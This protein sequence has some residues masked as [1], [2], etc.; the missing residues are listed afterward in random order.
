VK[1]KPN[2]VAGT[3]LREHARVGDALDISSPR[4]SF[5]LQPGEQP[6]LLLSAGIGAKPVLAMLHALVADRSTRQ[7]LWVHAARD[8]R[9]HPF[10]DEVRALMRELARGRSY[11]CYSRPG[12]SD[13]M[14]EDFDA[15][16][17]L[18]RSVFAEAGLPRDADV[19]LCGPTG[20]MADMK[21]E[22]AALGGGTRAN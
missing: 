8:R 13:K 6:L 12:S 15:T 10:V 5:I 1:I 17:H 7:V 21:Q 4:G 20:F 11:V 2:G 3:Y 22:L 19:Y 16:G 9:H 14:G 18:S